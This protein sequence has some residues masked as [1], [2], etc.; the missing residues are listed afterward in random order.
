MIADNIELLLNPHKETSKP[1]AQENIVIKEKIL[2]TG[3]P[4]IE[5]TDWISYQNNWYGFELK[6]PPNW[7]K[8]TSKSVAGGVKWEYRY[9]FQREKNNAEDFHFGFDVVVYNVK[10]VKELLNTEEYPTL[11]SEELK[12]QEACDKISGHLE[13]NQNYPAE[14]IHI[15]PNDNC[16]NPAFFYSLTR[17]E[18]IYNIVPTR[19]DSTE[20]INPEE[21]SKDFPEFIVVI[22]T[23]NL[24][25]IKR[26]KIQTKINAPIPVAAINVGGRLVC[27]KKND[28]P[29]YSHKGKGKHLDMECCLDPDA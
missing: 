1:V 16:Y 25:D 26:P 28:H 12:L 5:T 24:T 17:N 29:G 18:Y 13:E 7:G 10:K 14:K 19:K 27:A 22:S 3:N 6:Y 8:P 4:I 20:A 2:E 15:P 21:I 23:L 9:Q 11:K